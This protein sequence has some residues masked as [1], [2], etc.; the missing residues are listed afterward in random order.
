MGGGGGGGGGGGEGD[1]TKYDLYKYH[2][3]TEDAVTYIKYKV[4]ENKSSCFLRL[5]WLVCLSGGKS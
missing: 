3:I 5:L 4:P 1:I 2:D